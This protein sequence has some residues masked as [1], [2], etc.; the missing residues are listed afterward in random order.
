MALF[1][2][3]IPLW[4]LLGWLAIGLFGRRFRGPASGAL[5]SGAVAASFVCALA[6]LAALR[7]VRVEDAAVSITLPL[8]T[9]LGAGDLWVGA[10]LLVDALS[11]TMALA[12]SGVGFLIHVYSIGYMSDDPGASRYFSYLNL[13]MFAM[14][15]LVLAGNLLVLFVGWELVGVC[16]YLLIGYWFARPQAAAAG[17]KAFVVNRIGDAAF[18]LGLFLLFTSLGTLEI[19]K[20]RDGVGQLAAGTRTLAALLLFAGATG[21]SAQLP[22]HVWLPDAMEGPTP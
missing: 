19:M 14:L 22:L 18:L 16:S 3:L 11:V 1:A 9:W 4:P 8:F 20:I 17:R 2:L 7:G 13:F 6:A 15:L 10:S 5:A 12:V 21:K